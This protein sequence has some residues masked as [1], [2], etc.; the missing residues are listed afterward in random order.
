MPKRAAD[1]S[2]AASSSRSVPSTA[3]VGEL[4]A[5]RDPRS[6]HGGQ[7]RLPPATLAQLEEVAPGGY[8]LT[9]PEHLSKFLPPHATRDGKNNLLLNWDL[10]KLMPPTF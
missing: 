2:A 6:R 3:V 10:L 9:E 7:E 5:G 8:L 1:E 4:N